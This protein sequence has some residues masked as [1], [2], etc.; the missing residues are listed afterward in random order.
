MNSSE[1]LQALRIEIQDTDQDIWDEVE[2]VR[3]LQ[4]SIALMSRLIPKRTMTETVITREITGETL[5]ISGGTGTL[6]YAPIQAGSLSIPN[7]EEGVTN[8]YTVNLLTGVVTSVD[9]N[10]AD[11]DYTVSYDLDPYILD[12]SSLL[13]DYIKIERIEYPVGDTPPSLVVVQQ[14]IFGQ[15]LIFNTELTEDNHI[16]FTYLTPWTPPTADSDGDFPESLDNAVII[17][18]AGQA[19]IFKAEK[20]MHDALSEVTG[21]ATLLD[22]IGDLSLSAPSITAPTAPTLSTLTAPTDHTVSE[23]T[24]PDLPDT[25]TAPTAPTLSWTTVNTKLGLAETEI[26]TAAGYM[27][28]GDDLINTANTGKDAAAIFGEYSKAGVQNGLA[29]IQDAIVYLQQQQEELK[30][31]SHEVTSYASEVNQYA[32]EVSGTVGKYREEINSEMLNIHNANAKVARYRAEIEE[33]GNAIAKYAEQVRSYQVD[34]SKYQQEVAAFNANAQAIVNRAIQNLVLVESYIT[35]AGRFLASGQAKI[36][37]MLV[38]L[39]QKPEYSMYK[40]STEQFS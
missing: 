31:Y 27:D 3:A 2:L 40:S 39:G 25:P 10:L 6:T 5:T 20:Y 11:G 24:A 36:N 32:N 30:Q 4:K 35:I 19:L 34:V 18:S 38:M 13:P 15:Y 33:D 8:D 37:E 29:Y 28:S 9:S 22:T 12:I 7:K 26:E 14:E 23:P 17:G 21:I 1:I 16:R